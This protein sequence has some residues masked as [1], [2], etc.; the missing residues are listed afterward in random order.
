MHNSSMNVISSC[1]SS[2]H[3]ELRINTPKE[4]RDSCN[5]GRVPVS[6]DS[7]CTFEGTL[8][9]LMAGKADCL[10]PF[11]LEGDVTPQGRRF[12][13]LITQSWK[14]CSRHDESLLTSGEESI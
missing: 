9:D 13:T 6:G 2:V 5:T 10:K 4:D 8:S 1:A 3:L 12:Q 14:N 7:L 11:N